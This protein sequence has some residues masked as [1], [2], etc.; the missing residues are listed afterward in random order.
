MC[1]YDK[2]MRPVK[3]NEKTIVVKF[4]L[5]LK[6]FTYDINSEILSLDSW[7]TVSWIDQHLRWTPSDYDNIKQIHLSNS[8][9]WVPDLSVYNSHDQSTDPALITNTRCI[10]NYNGF[11]ICVP[12]SHVDA[13]CVAD[14]TKYPFDTQNCTVRFGSWVHKGEELDIRYRKPI[15]VLDDLVPNGEWELEKFN[16]YRNPGHYDC[17][18]NSTYPTVTLSLKINRLHGAHTASVIIPAIVGIIL[19]ITSLVMKPDKDRLTL[20]LANLIAQFLHMQYVSWMI[21]LKGNVVPQLIV[22]ARD[23]LLLCALTIVFTIVI[24]SLS[25]KKTTPPVWMSSTISFVISCKVGQFLI[26]NDHSVRG[27]AT[28]KGEEDG[29]TI[30]D[31]TEDHSTTNS[32]DWRIFASILDRLIFLSYV[33]VYFTLVIA[34]IP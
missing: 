19:T 11:V 7:V 29:S 30:I 4:H 32:Q 14:L 25:E 9:I 15:L 24:K 2:T 33:I 26:L 17:C 21:P 20:C 18:P 31:N 34:F 3:L 27:V 23:S 16:A 8:D 5:V 1:G 13:L 12:S 22:L 28:A 10:V 6:Y